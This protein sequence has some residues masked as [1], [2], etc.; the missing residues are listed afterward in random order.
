MRVRWPKFK[1]AM[2]FQMGE[3]FSEVRFDEPSIYTE[4]GANFIRDPCFR[5]ALLEEFQHARTDEVQPKHLA[6]ANVE[7]DGAVLV[8]GRADLVR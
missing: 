6:V 8:V 2:F 1:E 5:A 3:K 4:C 7:D